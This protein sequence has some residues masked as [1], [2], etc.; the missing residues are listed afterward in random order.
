[1]A[2]WAG[3]AWAGAGS[4]ASSTASATGACLAG[5]GD[6]VQDEEGQHDEAKEVEELV[7]YGGHH[8]TNSGGQAPSP[9]LGIKTWRILPDT[10]HP[11]YYPNVFLSYT[12]P[13][14]GS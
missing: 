9:V 8:D 1:M 11:V 14:T 10:S 5:D 2:A 13:D 6:D 12:E 7:D 4:T 3:C